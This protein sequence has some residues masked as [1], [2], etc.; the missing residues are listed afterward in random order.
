MNYDDVEREYLRSKPTKSTEK[1]GVNQEPVLNRI[2]SSTNDIQDTH[3]EGRINDVSARWN[4]N[5]YQRSIALF[6][7]EV[8]PK[9]NFSWFRLMILVVPGAF[10]IFFIRAFVVS[11]AQTV[12][13]DPQNNGAEVNS[14]ALREGNAPIPTNTHRDS[15]YA[16]E[17]SLKSKLRQKTQLVTPEQSLSDALR[18]DLE[19]VGLDIVRIDAR[20]LKWKGRLLNQPKSASITIVLNSN[21][22]VEN[23]VILASLVVA[24]YSVLLLEMPRFTLVIQDEDVALTKTISTEKAQFLYLQPGSLKDFIRSLSENP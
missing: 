24:K 16:L 19:Y 14:E 22:D 8:P 15:L 5:C 23:E 20:V 9:S 11:E 18:I 4:P 7:D 17:S 13:P 21:G 1:L 2:E 12:F 6:V 3:V 10:I